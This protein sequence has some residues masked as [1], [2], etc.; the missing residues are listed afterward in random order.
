MRVEVSVWEKFFSC[1]KVSFIEYKKYWVTNF[2]LVHCLVKE[3]HFFYSCILRNWM[4]AGGT[5]LLWWVK[6]SNLQLEHSV[7]S[8]HFMS[9]SSLQTWIS[10]SSFKKV[11][12][13]GFFCTSCEFRSGSS[14]LRWYAVLLKPSSRKVQFLWFTL[15]TVKQLSFPWGFDFREKIDK[16]RNP[17]LVFI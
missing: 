9:V 15:V 2:P 16:L 12:R 5:L 7:Y 4:D 6:K 17:P 14:K 11:S 13:D 3:S 1:Q 10:C 8:H